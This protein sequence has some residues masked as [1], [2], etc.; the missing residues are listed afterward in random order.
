MTALV[1]VHTE[2]EA[3]RAVAA[4]AKVIGVNARNLKTLDV[5]PETFGRIAPTIPDHIIKVAE[6]GVRDKH[7]LINYARQGADAILVGEGLVTAQDP[8]A[9][10]K[11]LV[12]A[13]KHPAC[14]T[15]SQ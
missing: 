9:A 8:G 10:A 2:E 5:D 3:E 15:K 7:D 14:P 11:A 13:G 12:A 6:S 4:G 1:E